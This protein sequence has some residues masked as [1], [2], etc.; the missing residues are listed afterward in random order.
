MSYVYIGEKARWERPFTVKRYLHPPRAEEVV[1]MWPD[2]KILFEPVSAD[3]WPWLYTASAVKLLLGET[4]EEIDFKRICYERDKDGIPVHAFSCRCG[5]ISLRMEAFCTAER[6]PAAYVRVTLKNR[7]P[8]PVMQ[9]ISLLARTGEMVRLTGS[10]PDGYAHL[11]TNVRNWGFIPAGFRFDGESLRDGNAVLRMA[12]IG[13]LHPVWQGNVKGVPWHL[14]GLLMLTCEIPAGGERDLFFTFRREGQPAAIPENYAAE[15]TKIRSFWA[16]ELSR[17]RRY[18]V[19]R[20][21]RSAGEMRTMYRTLIAGCLQMFARPVGKPYV[22]PRQGGLQ[23]NI[24]PAEAVCMLRALDRAGDFADYT[25][26]VIDFYLKELYVAEGADKGAVRTRDGSIGWGGDGAAVCETIARHILCRG[27]DAYEKYREPLLSMFRYIERT[28]AGTKE[29]EYAGK[30]LFPPVRSCDWSEVYQNWTKTD[31]YN[32]QAEEAAIRA[33]GKYADRA[34][35]EMEEEYADYL[36][37]MRRVLAAA[38]AAYSDGD[39]IVLPMHAGRKPTEPQTEGPFIA[40][41]VNLI[42]AGVCEAESDTARRIENY[43]KNRCMFRNGLHG[44]M[45]CGLLPG[46]QWDPWAGHVWYTGFVEQ[47]W[48]EVF[49]KQG[50]RAEAEETLE[51]QLRYSMTPEYY[52]CERYCDNDPYFVPWLP[53]GSGNGRIIDMLLDMSGAE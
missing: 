32:L 43:Y 23:N 17:I 28:R 24:W 20:G 47:M 19:W 8:Q 52:V 44:L 6:S 25:A 42:A 1:T 27:R 21:N 18:P 40:D 13:S 36:C 29:G 9:K 33:F 45:N 15:C 31:I 5:G 4:F 7:T 12:E 10:E 41:G 46:H 2:G 35:G 30:G 48:F 26:E 11:N 53:N 50:R 3:T 34:L 22:I 51:A 38:E 14:R 39:E 16:G 37:C 49:L